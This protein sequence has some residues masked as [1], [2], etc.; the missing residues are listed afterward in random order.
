MEKNYNILTHDKTTDMQPAAWEK[1]TV[2]IGVCFALILSVLAFYGHAQTPTLPFPY[3]FSV[4]TVM[5]K[6]YDDCRIII[7]MTDANGNMIAVNP[8]THNAANTNLYPLYNIS[9]HYQNFSAGTNKQYDTVNDIQVTAGLYCI[10]ITAY[11]PSSNGE[12]EMVDTTL[13]NIN[14]MADY[15]HLEAS[16]LSSWARST[17]DYGENEREFCGLHPAFPCADIGRIQ[18]MLT[19]GKF[20]YT[21][22]ILDAQQDTVRQATYYQRVNSGTDSIF[23]DYQDYYTFDSMAIGDYHILATDSCGYSIWMTITIPDGTPSYYDIYANNSIHCGDSNVIYF[24]CYRPTN[25]NINIR[26]Y[27][28]PYLDSIIQ[29]RFI[30]PGQD[31]TAWEHPQ[32]NLW[33]REW[34]Y[35]QDT[36]RLMDNYCPL[37]NDTIVLQFEDLCGDTIYKRRYYYTANFQYIDEH[38]STGVDM[39]V[40]PDTC[41]IRANSGISTQMYNYYGNPDWC[42]GCN[43]GNWDEFYPQEIPGRYYTCPLRYEVR[44]EIDSSLL[45]E[46]VESDD[47]SYLSSPVVFAVD[48]TLQ[49][50][51]TVTDAR[52]CLVSERHEVFVFHVSE[53]GDSRYPWRT[54]G[55][56]EDWNWDG[57][58]YDRYINVQEYSVDVEAFR[59]NQIVHLIES[60]LYNYFNFTAVCQNGEWTVTN[61]NP[62]NT[63][64]Y[65]EFPEP[66]ADSW[67]LTVRDSVCL[68]PGRYVFERTLPCGKDTITYVW[69]GSYKDPVEFVTYPEFTKRQ[70]CDKL[71]VHPV[72]P[73]VNAYHYTID[74]EWDNDE[75]NVEMYTDWYTNVHVIDGVAGGYNEWPNENGDLVFT[76]PGS[77]IIETYTYGPYSC[78][79]INHIDTFTFIPEYIDFDLGYAVICD[80]LSHTGNVLTHAIQGSEPYMYYLYN[81]SDLSGSMID[82][83]STGYFYNVTMDEG[84]QFSV[85]VTDS[86]HNSYYVNLTAA[87]LSQSVMAWEIG[88][89]SG[90]G[91]C[92]G[93]SVHLTALPFAFQAEYQWTGPNGFSSDTR[94]N[95][96]VLPYNG[97]SGWYV[98]EILNTGCSTVIT[99]SVYVQVIPA[100][101]VTL[102]SDP[103]VCPGAGA[104]ISITVQGSGP[105]TFDLFHAGAPASGSEI[106]SLN[107]NETLSQHYP[108]LSDNIFWADNI[109]D[110]VCAYHYLTDTLHI[111]VQNTITASSPVINTTDGTA[112]YGNAAT[113]RASSPISTPYCVSWYDNA[114]QEHLLKRDTISSPDMLSF[115]QIEH[116]YGDSALYVTVSNIDY[117]ASLYGTIYHTVNMN[118]GTTQMNIGESARLFDSGGESHH[119]GDNEHFTH[120]FSCP[121]ASNMEVVVNQAD[122]AMGDTLYLYSG[123]SVLPANLAGI[124]T[125]GVNF[126]QMTLNS[127]AV[128]FRFNSNWTNNRDGWIIDIRTP[129]VMTAVYGHLSPTNFDTIMADLCPSTTPYHVEGFP[130]FDISQPI[131]YLIDTTLISGG[132]CETIVHLH[133]KVHATSSTEIHDTLMPCQLP[134]TWNGVTFTD[135]ITQSVVLTNAAGCDSVVTMTMH[136]APPADST[137]VYDTIV[138]NQ[139]PYHTNGLTF[140]APGTQIATL[141]TQQGCDSIVTVHLF[142]H[143]NVTAEADSVICQN[144]LP[145]VWNGV[146]FT[147]TDTQTVVLTAHTG[148]DSTLTMH[149]TVNPTSQTNFVDTTCQG[150]AY[151][152]YGFSL[153]AAETVPGIMTLT[154][155]ETNQYNCDSTIT[156]TLLVTPVITP[157]FYAEPDKA[158][159]SESPAVQ[160]TNTTDISDI[161]MMS[162]YWV[163]DFDDGTTDSTTN[164]NNQHLYTQWG[165]YSVT[166]TLVVNGCESESSIPVIIEAD[167]GFPNVITPNGDGFNDVFI[168]K[169]LNPDR[170]NRLV[171]ADRWGKIVFS[172]NNYQTYMKEGVVYNAESGFGNGDISEGV[173]YYTFYYQGVVRELQFNGSITVIR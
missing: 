169:D 82:T 119:Y 35:F 55:N 149:L 51:I 168:I 106:Y 37:Y 61:D 108:I 43:W 5:G 118:N 85:M 116:L 68:A 89:E 15:D 2:A 104:D 76:V 138:E 49:A 156:L 162:Y 87:S 56:R 44:S 103:M 52:G 86:C 73:Q 152:G 130:D 170:S 129:V 96:F 12:L 98:L 120:T 69:S 142:V 128:T 100:P 147:K 40:T 62:A 34:I 20:P 102:L 132:T 139:L 88:N 67:M 150:A 38:L 6:C 109:S 25:N 151:E 80:Y 14:V 148:A 117:C 19:K 140:N 111:A 112:C 30:N 1:M 126:T 125:S 70:V 121:N 113:L 137:T 18:V 42:G 24:S 135:F 143:F 105:V 134:V 127:S 41:F 97:E 91:H 83:S 114:Q 81:G 45:S 11:V 57:C 101:R 13:C 59:K 4:E 165:D 172:T 58:C 23:A 29:F 27:E 47:F 65:V 63:S 154:R 54:W 8:Q 144:N 22:T 171:I 48:T 78:A 71:F 160:F 39:D 90:L 84:Q 124:I 167:L 161:S 107:P 3:N 33:D 74:P 110:S 99:D 79:Y 77:Y 21:I 163:W 164:Y 16:V 75:P 72:Q 50:H 166:L 158:L 159:L 94:V 153:T 141:T 17:S 133:L 131:E 173:Y 145:L 10:G 46:P 31:T 36:L 66:E 123:N 146:T 155:V 136:W 60:P 9:Y 157:S 7:T 32:F 115:C 53:A 26:D 95:D 122:I 64:T 28:L 93:D 92:E